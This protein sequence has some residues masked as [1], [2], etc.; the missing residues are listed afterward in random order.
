MA[1]VIVG[2]VISI[3]AYALVVLPAF[4]LKWGFVAEPDT[5][6]DDLSELLDVELME[7]GTG[8]E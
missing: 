3:A 4:Y 1:W 8:G 5:V 2:G 6:A 7:L